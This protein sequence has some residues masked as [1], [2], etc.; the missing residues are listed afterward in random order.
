MKIR[1]G[2]L[3]VLSIVVL[4]TGSGIWSENALEDAAIKNAAAA[5]KQALAFTGFERT[6]DTSGVKA[7][8]YRKQL[9]LRKCAEL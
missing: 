4:L 2:L 5:Y 7:N 8:Q 9:L 6:W 1:Q 3:A